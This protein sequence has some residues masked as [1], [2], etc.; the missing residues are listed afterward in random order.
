VYLRH[1]GHVCYRGAFLFLKPSLSDVSNIYTLP[2][3]RAVWVTYLVTVVVFSYAL[4]ITQRTESGID[5]SKGARPLSLSDSF[6]TTI[7]IIC[8]EGLFY[9]V[10]LLFNITEKFTFFIIHVYVSSI[11]DV[12][13]NGRIV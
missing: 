13:S 8:Q 3:S 5:D 1:S 9:D 7:G 4:Y 2:F 11:R 12:T 6:F 10:V